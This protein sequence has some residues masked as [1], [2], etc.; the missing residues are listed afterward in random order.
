M[1]TSG[2]EPVR[3]SARDLD[4]LL[5][6]VDASLGLASIIVRTTVRSVR[7][8]RALTSP[9]LRRVERL[10]GVTTPTGA[11]VR[12]LHRRG[13]PAREH[14]TMTGPQVID[15]VVPVLL[16]QVLSRIDLTDVVRRHVDLNGLVADIDV[17]AVAARLDVDAVAARLDIDSVAG[18]LDVDS[19]AARLDLASLVS[20]VL[21]VV[22]LVAVA[23]EVIDAV[24][25]PDIIRDSSG[26][27]TSDTVR[28]TRMRSAAADQA[29]GR[30]R[31]RFLP[32]REGTRVLIVPSVR[33]DQP[34][35]DLPTQ[36]ESL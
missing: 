19:V 10:P 12:S 28:G 15:I 23:Q 18:R 29:L 32:R 3:R 25:L 9:I 11:L 7:V 8:T 30:V 33:P 22:D 26:A 13:A 4:R 34:G 24:N 1:S 27:L 31:D 5:P 20:A 36:P 16:E 14:L 17:D 35:P 2:E 21:A 6:V